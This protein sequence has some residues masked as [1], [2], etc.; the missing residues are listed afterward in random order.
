MTMRGERKLRPAN[1][2]GTRRERK[3]EMEKKS[4]RAFACDA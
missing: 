3:G 2:S 1:H 4:D